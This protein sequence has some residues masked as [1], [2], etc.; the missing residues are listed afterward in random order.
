MWTSASPCLHVLRHALAGVQPLFDLG[1]R[2]V[3]RHDERACQ[4]GLTLV[5][6]STQLE[7]YCPTYSP[8]YLTKVSQRCSS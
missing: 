3:A 6:I 5:P 8:I 4:Q 7:L 1:V 2:D